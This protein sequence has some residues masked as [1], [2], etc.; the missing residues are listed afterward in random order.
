MV[1]LL[2]L[3]LLYP[4]SSLVALDLILFSVSRPF[5][6]HL[7]DFENQKV[8]KL[9]ARSNQVAL[10][11]CFRWMG[12]GGIVELCIYFFLFFSLSFHIEHIDPSVRIQRTTTMF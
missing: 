6:H 2:L 1:L 3:L 4:F 10:I 9:F 12:V 5:S 7:I 8:L 11:T